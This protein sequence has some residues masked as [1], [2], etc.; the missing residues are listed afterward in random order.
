VIPQK[1]PIPAKAVYRKFDK[2]GW[3][4]FVENASNSLHSTAGQAGFCP[5]PGDASWEPGLKPGY[6]CVQ[7][8]L[9]DG[10]PN[11]TD[12]LVN[13]AI[14]DPGFVGVEVAVEP[15]PPAPV[16]NIT[17]SGK[18]RGG[19]LDAS[20]LAL[21]GLL[22]AAHSRRR[23]GKSLSKS[24][25]AVT[26]GTRLGRATSPLLAV[27]LTAATSLAANQTHSAEADWLS[28]TYVR[29][30][31][32]SLKGGESEADF[33]S[34]LAAT[35]PSYSLQRYDI[36]R[37]GWDLSLG[38]SFTEQWAVELGYKDLGKVQVDFASRLET[39]AAT[40]AALADNYPHASGGW[41]LAGAYRHSLGEQLSLVG[42]AGLYR[43][44]SRV[45]INTPAIAPP[46]QSG[47]DFLAGLELQYAITPQ[48]GIGAT[49][50]QVFVEDGVISLGLGVRW[51]FY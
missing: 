28:N 48:I 14:A 38:K 31:L 18:K 13:A 39:P 44:Q 3:R 1:A 8:T 45:D 23:T 42:R 9:E 46:E 41:T 25:Q 27:S 32:L 47:T 7:L 2:N 51:S 15:P 6:Y 40:A 35:S 49:L 17:S 4:N 30:N 24:A 5:P 37:T 33:N 43:W 26:T 34:Q 20:L 22:V 29:L 50:E 19:S 36:N 21:L 11:D 10:G 16:Q 12:G